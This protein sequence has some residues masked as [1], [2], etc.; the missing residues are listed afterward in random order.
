[1]QCVKSKGDKAARLDPV[2]VDGDIARRQASNAC[3]RR[4][5]S[6]CLVQHLSREPQLRHIGRRQLLIADHGG[7][8]GDAAGDVGVAPQR[9]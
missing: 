4:A 7:L 9:P 2:A 5:H 6:Q 1:M 3:G 8:R